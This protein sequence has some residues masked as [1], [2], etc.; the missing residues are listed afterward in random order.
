[1]KR[2]RVGAGQRGSSNPYTVAKDLLQHS[3]SAA[4]PDEGS[5][6]DKE[7]SSAVTSSIGARAAVAA[8]SLGSPTKTGKATT[9]RK[10]QKLA[11]AA[12]TSRNISHYFA[13]KETPARSQTPPPEPHS[14]LDD[15]P[16]TL[17]PV[18]PEAGGG[19]PASS[20]AAAARTDIIT[21]PDD[22]EEEEKKEEKEEK[23]DFEAHKSQ[24]PEQEE[25]QDK[26][27]ESVSE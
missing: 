26:C 23:D 24:T 9:S 11:E 7:A 6:G 20:E 21:V 17:S 27:T 16:W 15:G 14:E 25:T 4:P 8:A 3:E 10:Q 5:A 19:S 12:K 1:M 2:K 18:A 13:K 22:D